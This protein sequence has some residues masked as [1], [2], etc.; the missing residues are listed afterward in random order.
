M[1]AD[2]P[3]SQTT[4]EE[5]VDSQGVNP[6]GVQ[7]VELH[8]PST[9]KEMDK[10]RERYENTLHLCAHLYKDIS[11]RDDMRMVATAVAPYLTDY[12]TM[13]ETLKKSQDWFEGTKVQM[14]PKNEF[15]NQ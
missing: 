4:D 9:K 5:D 10:I 14:L 8:R 7:N 1:D 3:H 11:L 13:L 12:T 6:E 2:K 15:E